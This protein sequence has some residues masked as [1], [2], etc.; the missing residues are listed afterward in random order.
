MNRENV[1]MKNARSILLPLRASGLR[2]MIPFI[3]SIILGLKVL[4]G[5]CE[6]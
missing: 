2:T 3:K 6:D 5:F 1:R 4:K